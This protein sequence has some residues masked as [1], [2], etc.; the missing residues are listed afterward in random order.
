MQACEKH[1]KCIVVFNAGGCPFCKEEETFR[2][3]WEEVERLLTA[4][5]ELKRDVEE[6][7]L[8]LK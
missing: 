7:G 8:K 3:I 5:K 1:E 2:I 4:L 6:A